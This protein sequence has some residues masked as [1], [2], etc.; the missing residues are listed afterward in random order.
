VK[1]AN[2]MSKASK[3]VLIVL[4]IVLVVMAAIHLFGGPLRTSLAHAIHG[5]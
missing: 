5:Q 2:L 1:G 3:P 4:A